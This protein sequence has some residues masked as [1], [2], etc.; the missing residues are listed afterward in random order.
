MPYWRLASYYFFYFGSLG[1]LVPYWGLYLQE[2]GFSP[3]A[4]G[5][6]VAILM[7]TKIVAP[8]LWGWLADRRG[9]RMP[10]VRLATLLS[11]IC[12]TAIFVADGFVEMALVM[13]LFSFFW[14]ASLPQVEAVTFS[15]LG[16]RVNRYAS[17]RLWGS[18]GFILSVGLLGLGLQHLGTSVVPMVVLVLY[19]GIWVSSL[20]VPEGPMRWGE[21]PSPSVMALLRRP[22]ILAFLAT[23]LLMQMSHGAYY[24]FYS[25]HLKA[26]GY[27]TP[28]VGA[29][30][31]WAVVVEV[32]VFLV[33]HRLLEA[34]GAR[35]VL[36]ASVALAVLRWLLIAGFTDLIAVQVLAQA[37]HA[38]TFGAFHAAAIHLAYHYFPGRTQG[39]GQA[40]YNSLSFGAGGAA[41]ALLCGYLWSA[42]GAAP[43]F[44]VSAGIAVLAWWLAWFWVDRARRY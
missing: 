4:I 28:V 18:I 35:R 10:I 42:F 26:A 38:A 36:L 5:Q 1:A 2:R 24:A 6:L 14:N 23:G 20:L 3:L 37:M 34:F 15:H 30:W 17:I 43:T 25:I 33:M 13:V 11:T 22:E 44:A 27:A 39:R 21:T 9:Y 29:L 19:C 32:L 40:L 31:A 16:E 7:A 41:G 8:N 12:F